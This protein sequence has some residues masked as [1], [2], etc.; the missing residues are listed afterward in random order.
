MIEL[1]DGLYAGK[2][3]PD[4]SGG[5]SAYKRKYGVTIDAILGDVDSDGKLVLPTTPHDVVLTGVKTVG[6]GGLRYKF[7]HAAINSVSAPDLEELLTSFSCE[8][9]F[10]AA[11]V[12]SI[13]F[14]KLKTIKYSSVMHWMFR[15]CDLTTA[16]FPV[17]EE[18]SGDQCMA[19]LFYNNTNLTTV[20]FPALSNVGSVVTQFKDM[21]KNCSDVTVHFPAAM[22]TT[23]QAWD[24]VVA[25]FGGTN[26]TVLF[27][28]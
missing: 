24:D 22:E 1:L 18:I 28:L 9:A 17:L 25:G 14:P 3:N 26:T 23:M 15:E 8:S 12:K 6:S 5:G 13:S 27:D 16:E 21:L 2:A 19:G 11:G 20:S 7:Y 10:Y 4:N